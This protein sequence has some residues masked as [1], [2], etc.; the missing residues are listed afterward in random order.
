[1]DNDLITNSLI[2]KTNNIV[3]YLEKFD[4]IF[5]YLIEKKKINLFDKDKD[6]QNLEELENSSELYK[7]IS[8]LTELFIFIRS[9]HGSIIVLLN[10]LINKISSDNTNLSDE[11]IYKQYDLSTFYSISQDIFNV[12]SNIDYEYKL[13]ASKF[14]KFINKNTLRLIL[15]VNNKNDKF[16][17]IINLLNGKN[18]ENVYDVIITDESKINIKSITNKDIKLTINNKPTLFIINGEVITEVSLEKNNTI[19]KLNSLIT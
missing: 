15:V 9:E 19:E 6:I 8:E 4:N 16:V 3:K 18:P 10:K 14:P 5:K 7:K 17:N 1:M 12:I 13:I 2:T 11:I